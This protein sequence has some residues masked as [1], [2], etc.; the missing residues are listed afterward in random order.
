[1]SLSQRGGCEWEEKVEEW[2]VHYRLTL[3]NVRFQCYMNKSFVVHNMNL[4][5]GNTHQMLMSLLS[6]AFRI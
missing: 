1:M 2:F 3:R 4:N 6:I 5:V